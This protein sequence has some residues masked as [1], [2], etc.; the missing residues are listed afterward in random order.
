MFFGICGLY[1]KVFVCVSRCYNV[2][3]VNIVII[4]N[5]CYGVVCVYIIVFNVVFLLLLWDF[6][7]VF[8]DYFL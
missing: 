7:F 2:N 1:C 6:I 8:C 4:C 3:N 5:I